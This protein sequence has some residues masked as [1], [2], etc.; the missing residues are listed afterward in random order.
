M[1][2]SRQD[3]ISI[4]EGN[5][6]LRDKNPQ[7]NGVFFLDKNTPKSANP[8]PSKPDQANIPAQHSSDAEQP[9]GNKYHNQK[10]FVYEDGF[11]C[12]GKKD[13]AHGKPVT[14]YDSVKEFNRWNELLLLE[15]AGAVKDL[16]RQVTLTIQ[17]AFRC[18]GEK[19]QA[20]QYKADFM[21]RDAK[22]NWETVVEDVKGF[23]EK[24]GKYITT[25]DFT[26]KWKLLKC[27]YPEYWF[28]IF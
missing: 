14:V 24:T 11:C 15:K 28:E 2:L 10:V 6:S 25:K 20:I 21:Y 18:R 3:L 4:F 12:F 27:K 7:Y 26:L 9:K 1:E 5:K 19:I 23:S 22:H 17:E 13:P 8:A 16:R